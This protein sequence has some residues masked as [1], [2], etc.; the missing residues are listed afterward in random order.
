MYTSRCITNIVS[1]GECIQSAASSNSS[2]M[3]ILNNMN[4]STC[5]TL[6]GKSE[7]TKPVIMKLQVNKTCVNGPDV[8]KVGNTLVTGSEFGF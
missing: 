8:S 2:E 1:P 4:E 3:D 5:M 7:E 6:N